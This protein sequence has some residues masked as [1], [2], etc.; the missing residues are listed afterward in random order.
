MIIQ[1]NEL[2]KQLSRMAGIAKTKVS[3]PVLECVLI[4]GE[5]KK[6]RVSNLDQEASCLFDFE[7]EGFNCAV[8]FKTFLNILSS[9]KDTQVELELKGSQLFIHGGDSKFKLPVMPDGEF[10]P[11]VAPKHNDKSFQLP[12]PV[13]EEGIASVIRSS[14]KDEARFVLNGVLIE[15]EGNNTA[16]VATDGR[17]LTARGGKDIHDSQLILPLPTCN[18][19]KS[20][21]SGFE[22]VEI[23]HNERSVWFNFANEQGETLTIRSK[24]TEGKF[25]NWRAVVPKRYKSVVKVNRES[26]IAAIRRVD[27]VGGGDSTVIFNFDKDSLKISKATVD[28]DASDTIKAECSVNGSVG[29][30]AH[31]ILDFLDT[32]R[33]QD[34]VI[35][36]QEDLPINPIRLESGDVVGIVMPMRIN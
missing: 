35:R 28:G 24:L 7:G 30:N 34:I 20:A 3:L 1:A 16:F 25:P 6:L 23:F 8:G 15:R 13:L 9:L 32:S 27:L 21:A 22:W 12:V 10:P 5:K 17:R 33:S 19:L 14:S 26:L 11:E 18:A 36:L 4:D 2:I 31:F 29:Y